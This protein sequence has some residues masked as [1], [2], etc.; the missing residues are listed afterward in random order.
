VAIS[1]PQAPSPAPPREGASPRPVVMLATFAVPFDRD[2]AAVAVNAAIEAGAKL[3]CVD[4]LDESIRTT[5]PPHHVVATAA[6]LVELPDDR[7]AIRRSVAEW[8]EAGLPVEHLR[9]HT[10]QPVEALVEVAAKRSAALVVLGPDRARFRRRKLR[11]IARKLRERTSFLL[12]VAGEEPE[13]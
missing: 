5:W 10:P 2:A 7:D 9:V 6:R 4:I 1:R 11:R 3:V 8:A 13:L 12:W